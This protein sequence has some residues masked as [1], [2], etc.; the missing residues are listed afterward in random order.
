MIIA[1]P[2]AGGYPMRLCERHRRHLERGLAL[3]GLSHLRKDDAR[4]ALFNALLES[5]DA[6]AFDPLV[7]AVF[8]IV[9][10]A[11]HDGGFH[12]LGSDGG[13]AEYCPL[14]EAE[15]LRDLSLAENWLDGACDDQLAKAR[16]L[17]LVAPEW[18]I[19]VLS[20]AQARDMVAAGLLQD[21]DYLIS[22]PLPL[23]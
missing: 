17:G 23:A 4:R 2:L 6:A 22:G 5:D 1:L 15:R 18:A 16:R 20:E 14:C 21:G 8:A 12:L 13:G 11:L 10:R 19:T 3:R 9:A 7:G